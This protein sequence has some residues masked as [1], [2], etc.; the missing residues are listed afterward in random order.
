[1]GL[2]VSF[3]IQHTSSKE[4][5][6]QRFYFSVIMISYADLGCLVYPSTDGPRYLPGGSATAAVALS[7]GL[8]HFALE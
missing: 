5:K 7:V 1:M 3:S 4:W 8:Y 2:T 6:P